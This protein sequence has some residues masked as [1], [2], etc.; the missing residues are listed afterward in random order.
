MTML[1]WGRM[2]TARWGGLARRRGSGCWGQALVHC[3]GIPRPGQIRVPVI[4]TRRPKLIGAAAP[5]CPAP[6]MTLEDG[7]FERE[8]ASAGQKRS[9]ILPLER[10]V[11]RA[12]QS[13]TQAWPQVDPFRPG[14]IHHKLR[15]CRRGEPGQRFAIVPGHPLRWV[16]LQLLGVPG[17]AGACGGRDP[18]CILNGVLVLSY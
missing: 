2:A 16:S 9:R 10:P 6:W 3:G 13:V 4:D 17:A 7:L 18:L 15:G 5:F 14:R 1:A 8:F 11:W 12:V